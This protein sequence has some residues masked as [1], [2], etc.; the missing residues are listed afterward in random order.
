MPLQVITAPGHDLSRSLGWLALWWIET[1]VQHGPGDVSGQ[2]IVNNDE[3]SDFIVSCYCLD[4]N[5]RR[6]YDSAFFS[7]PKGC[8]KSEVAAMLSLFEALGPC[9]I[10]T[11]SFGA[12]MFAK[13][14]E[15]YTFLD[16]T[17]TYQ[18]GEPMGRRQTNPYIRIMA[19]EEGQAGNVYDTIYQNLDT[20][21]LSELKAI[22]MDVGQS[23]IMLPPP[24]GG[25]I[26][27]STAGAASKDGG[28]ET[29]AVFDE[30]HLYD[31]NVL[32][33]MYATVTRNLTKRG[34]TAEPWYLETTTMYDPGAN[35]VAESTYKY[36][37]KILEGKTKR[38]RLYFNHRYSALP[39]KELGDE[40][41]LRAAIAEAYGGALDWNDVD[42]IIDKIL[43][44]RTSVRA[45]MR[46]YLNAITAASDA[47]VTP[48]QMYEVAAYQDIVDKY[49]NDPDLD[50]RDAF[51]EIVTPGTKITLGFDGSLKH[52]ST[53]LIGCRVEDGLLF[54]IRIDE[55]PDGPEA[56]LWQVDQEAFDAAVDWAFD[57]YDVVGF[58]ADPPYWEQRIE[59]WDREHG[60][61]LQVDNGRERIKWRT[62]VE[63][64]MVGA[65]NRVFTAIQS[66]TAKILADPQLQRHFQNG[67][68][69]HRRAGD[70]VFKEA[71]S[72]EKKIDGAI[73]ATLAYEA[74]DRYLNGDHEDENDTFDL[75]FR[76]A[77]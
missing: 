63:T 51:K 66:K 30:T 9:R 20:G 35:S 22:G 65:L 71:P 19:T 55:C 26:Q 77:G 12:P 56:K 38:A 70:L 68:V 17:Y 57:T 72:S 44:Y 16:Q 15:T 75:P 2:P 40:D 46:Y 67:R 18:P 37:Q 59:A 21:P 54:P 60:E 53:A 76:M 4:G 52:D 50:V 8:N 61:G 36:A 47:W 5:G 23:R 62:N 27:P 31:S 49:Q 29:F 13:G 58:F 32:R 7:R 48:Q 3:Y 69:R 34:K 24:W 74:R 45:S 14:G 11:D 43:D 25:Q 33:E 28:K 1:F 73:A 39:E 6:L 42:S 41:K 64:R 10:L